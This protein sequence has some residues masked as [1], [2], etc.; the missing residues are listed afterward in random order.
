MADD[1][2]TSKTLERSEDSK[3]NPT[4]DASDRIAGLAV[5]VGLPITTVVAA[6]VIAYL[7]SIGP[8]ILALVTGALLGAIV[9]LWASL[10]SLVGDA[11]LDPALDEAAAVARAQRG[12]LRGE[13]KRIALRAL[14]DLEH[15]HNIG[16][17]DD[18]DY[19]RLVTHY[20]AEAKA[21][22]R[23][24]DEE[25]EPYREKAERLAKE[26][27]D[28]KLPK[29]ATKSPA[30]KP[31]PEPEPADED[32]AADEDER[33][34]EH[35][36]EKLVAAVSAPKLEARPRCPKCRTRNDGDAAFCKKCG[37]VL[38]EPAAGLL[39]DEDDEDD[40]EEEDG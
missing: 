13:R 34:H 22:M 27:L 3:D 14:K 32:E 2:K 33:E 10:R 16:K 11:G 19:E 37:T 31:E 6:L 30:K 18:D 29:T 8:A 36:E 1:V 15:E 20:R 17:L 12:G 7:T 28:K 9:L 21:A 26:Y 38:K 35:E 40:E 4:D 25:I 24:I 39:T 23:E 5:R